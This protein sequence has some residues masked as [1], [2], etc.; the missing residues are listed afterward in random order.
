MTAATAILLG[1]AFA[2]AF[3]AG[4]AVVLAAKMLPRPRRFGFSVIEDAA[5][6]RG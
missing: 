1:F 3:L 5:D 4:V 2:S 6:E